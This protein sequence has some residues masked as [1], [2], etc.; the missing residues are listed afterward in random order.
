MNTGSDAK[1]SEKITGR[2]EV[3]EC[4]NTQKLSVQE[5]NTMEYGQFLLL[6]C[7]RHQFHKQ[8]NTTII[9]YVVFEY[10]FRATFI[11]SD[12]KNQII[13]EQENYARW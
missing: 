12:L 4:S 10:K 3:F 9:S 7:I 1:I 6:N 5:Q 13:S 8:E 2:R 11:K